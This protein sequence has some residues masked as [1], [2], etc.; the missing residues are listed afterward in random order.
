MAEVIPTEDAPAP[1][2]ACSQAFRSG[3]TLWLAG[4]V[5]IDPP[6]GK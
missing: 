2:G 5:G 6:T 3:S 4:P 1:G